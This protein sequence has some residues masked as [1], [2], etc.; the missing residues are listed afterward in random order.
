MQITNLVGIMFRHLRVDVL[1]KLSAQV[2][3]RLTHPDYA[4]VREV[5]FRHIGSVPNQIFIYDDLV[6][7][8]HGSPLLAY[9]PQEERDKAID[10]LHANNIAI[11]PYRTK[12]EVTVLAES[13]LDE[14]DRNLIFRLAVSSPKCNGPE[15]V[16]GE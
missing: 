1:G 6:Q 14:L 8:E 15:L 16:N 11:A 7:G 10:F 3:S 9:P 2:L 5:L 12:A 13:F 4:N